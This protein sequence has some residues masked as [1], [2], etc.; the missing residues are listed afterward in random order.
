MI[1]VV[2]VAAFA[3]T[4]AVVAG[5]VGQPSAQMLRLFTRFVGSVI[6]L[7]KPPSRSSMPATVSVTL[8]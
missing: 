3:V 5:P 7:R 6:G 8:P 2:F 1:Q 4:N